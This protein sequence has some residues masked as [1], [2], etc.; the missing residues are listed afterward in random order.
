MSSP[1]FADHMASRPAGI[2]GLTSSRN[3][4]E[5]LG[6]LAKVVEIWGSRMRRGAKVSNLHAWGIRRL[7]F[8]NRPIEG[9]RL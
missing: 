5:E 1:L 8:S 3:E 2:P 6:W 7:D 4:S 9:V